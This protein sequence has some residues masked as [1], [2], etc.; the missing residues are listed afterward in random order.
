MNDE[1]YKK[2]ALKFLRENITA[3]IATSKDGTH[4]RAVTIYYDVDDDFNFY[5]LTAVNTGKYADLTENSNIGI[6]VG[7]GP[8]YITIQGG[9][10]ADLVESGSDEENE[11]IVNINKRLHPNDYHWPL[12]QIPRFLNAEVAVFKMTPKWLVMLNLDK[13]GHLD[14]Y[15]ED[16][17]TLI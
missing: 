6:A 5:F 10:V 17:H 3:A 7:F 13:E 14:S 4:L 12:F 9:G 2:A 16:F 15:K 1:Q 11:I 8:P